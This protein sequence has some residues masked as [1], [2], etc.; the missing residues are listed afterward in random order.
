[1]YV[2]FAYL[3][4]IYCL[5]SITQISSEKKH[6]FFLSWNVPVAEEEKIR[7]IN[8]NW[9]EVG[10]S[11]C[12]CVC[13]D[14]Y[15]AILC[16]YFYFHIEPVFMYRL[17]C[18]VCCEYA[19]KY[20]ALY[21][22]VNYIWMFLSLSVGQNWTKKKKFFS[23]TLILFLFTIVVTFFV[24]IQYCFIYLLYFSL[25]RLFFSHSKLKLLEK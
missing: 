6:I 20:T 12:V 24:H 14:G 16:I 4:H 8:E 18:I 13:D 7:Q 22:T 9:P 23:F 15:R 2:C 17:Y 10:V 19:R 25:C 5:L 3:I 1:M 21:L 11:V